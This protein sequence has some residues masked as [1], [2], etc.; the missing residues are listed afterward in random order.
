MAKD[1][2]ASASAAATR[3]VELVVALLIVAAGVVV[4]VD[5]FRVGAGWGADGPESGYFPNFIGW[6]LAGTGLCIAG[7][8][9][10]RWKPLAGKVFVMRDELGPVLAMLLP[11][12]V[13]VIVLAFIGIYV[14]SA[15]YIATFMIWQGRYRLLPTLVIS[16]AV[17]VAIFLLFEIWFLVPLPKGPLEHL[18]GY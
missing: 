2:R 14:A 1:N 18:L 3:W 17:P 12:V 11:T 13:Y 16:I 4:L 9:L 15:L 5:S 10:I 6:I 8:T 7:G